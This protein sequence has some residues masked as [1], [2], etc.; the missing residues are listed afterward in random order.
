MYQIYQQKKNLTKNQKY[1]KKHL[2][3]Q[4]DMKKLD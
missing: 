2:T 3:Q 1:E 4:Q